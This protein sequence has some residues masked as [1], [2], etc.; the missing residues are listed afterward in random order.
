MIE[1]IILREIDVRAALA[2]KLKQLRQ[3]AK[4]STKEVG[5]AVGKSDKTINAWEHGRGQPDAEMLFLLKDVFNIQSMEQFFPASHNIADVERKHPQLSQAELSHIQKYRVLDTHGKEIVDIVLDKEHERCTTAVEP[6]T[7]RLI[8]MPVYNDPA[9]AGIPLYAESEFERMDFDESLV[10]AD[11]DFGV[12]IS[13]AS[14]EPTIQD[15]QIVWVKKTES[16]STNHIGIFMLAGGE[17][18][19]KRAKVNEKGRI[20]ELL[21]DNPAYDP[22]SGETLDGLRIV[23]EVILSGV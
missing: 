18:V 3:Q 8:S 11:A 4:L 7:A 21:S 5:D 17:A 15:A 19:C 20:T 1:V 10:P 14:M 23:G 9:A 6:R 16:I 2:S 22:I 13:G 12:R